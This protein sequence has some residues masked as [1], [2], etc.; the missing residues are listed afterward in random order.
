M[1]IRAHIQALNASIEAVR[2]GDHGKG[3]AVVADEVKKL[4][5][6]SKQ[7][8]EQIVSLTLEIQ[9]GTKNVENA[10]D[11]GLLS[12]TKG[13]EITMEQI[14]DVSMELSQNAQNL[15]DLVRK[16]KL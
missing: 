15:N 16:F 8:A 14:N 6:Q 4:A 5:E 3:F 1:F 10:V 2:A 12:V 11:K 9:K 13:V 7:S